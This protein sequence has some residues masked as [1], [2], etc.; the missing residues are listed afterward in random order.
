MRIAS[1]N[2]NGLRAAWEK[3]LAQW[4]AGTRADLVLLQ[5][6]RAHE[7][8]LAEEMRSPAGWG[9]AFASG[10]RRGYSGVAAFWN[11]SRTGEPDE[12]RIGLGVPRFDAE[13]RS[14]MVRFGDLCV[15]GC[16]FPNG[17]QGTERVDFKLDFYDVLLG[18]IGDLRREGFDVVVGGDFNTAHRPIDL[19]RP[20]ENRN[21]S[22]FMP[23]ERAWLDRWFADGWV[24]SYRHLHPDER[25]VYTWWSVLT[26][27]RA[28]NVG[29]RLDYLVVDRAASDRILRAEVDASVAG[30]DHA[31]VFLELAGRGGGD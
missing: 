24:D 5:E 15:F 27:A 7:E 6:T 8:Q 1:W 11:R 17:G 26:D 4:L 2:V 30:S 10:D 29:W 19:A 14:V 20:G 18:R 16:Y 13:G 23:E 3:G 9:S 22:G 31:P 12:V 25:D 21:T 28:R